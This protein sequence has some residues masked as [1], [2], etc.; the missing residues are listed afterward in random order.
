[1]GFL[2][3]ENISHQYF[4][5]SSY[6]KAIEDINLTIEEGDFVSFLGPSGCGKSTILS[7][8]SGLIAPTE[9]NVFVN[10]SPISKQSTTIGYMLQEDYLFPWKTIQQNVLL[11]PHIQRNVTQEI[12]AKAIHI[13]EDMGLGKV[14]TDYPSQLSGGMRQRA[15]LARTLITN[16]HIFLLDEP[17]S[18]L[19]YQ[20]KL[21]LENLVANTLK[22]YNKT[23]LLV[24]HDIGEAIAMSDCI[25]LLSAN[26]GK[27]AATFHVPSHLKSLDP[28]DARQDAD[29]NELFQEIWKELNALEHNS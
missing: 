2:T 4:T 6:T 14:V 17:F 15:A 23:S 28:F 20:T 21:K 25:Y 3:L 7:I 18:A 22:K 12:E 19:D 10:G 8:V 16:P 24:T 11:G 13:L 29:F 9:G 1:M 27:V 5:T 26:P